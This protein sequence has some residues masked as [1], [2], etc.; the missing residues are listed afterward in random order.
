MKL[1][2][3]I[4]FLTAL[5]VLALYGVAL[6]YLRIVEPSQAFVGA[7]LDG[8]KRLAVSGEVSLP[9]DTVRVTTDDGVSVLLL[10]S[11][12]ADS[13]D[14]PWVIYFYGRYDE[15]TPY[16]HAEALA[17]TTAGLRRLIPLECGHEDAVELERDRMLG[18]LEDFLGELP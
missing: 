7:D 2:R 17:E 16:S 9:W 11:R 15:V 10:E 18:A 14:A 8:D 5:L 1:L 3:R 4:V 13:V 12:L 6:A